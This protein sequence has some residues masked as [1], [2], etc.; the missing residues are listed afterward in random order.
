MRRGCES[1]ICFSWRAKGDPSALLSHLMC[2]H[3]DVISEGRRGDTHI[4]AGKVPLKS[5]EKKILAMM[6]VKH[7]NRHLEQL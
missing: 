3:R 5:K 6:V 2:G 1:L 4:I 7:W